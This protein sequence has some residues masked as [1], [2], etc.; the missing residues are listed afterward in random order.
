MLSQR[1]SLLADLRA[2]Q[3]DAVTQ[4]LLLPIDVL[5]GMT[6]CLPGRGIDNF[7]PDKLPSHQLNALK[8]ARAYTDAVPDNPLSEQSRRL[9]QQVD[10]APQKKSVVL[11][12]CGL[13]KLPLKAILGGI[14]LS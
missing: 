2:G 12:A 6:A 10:P 14:V 11:P 4:R 13:T 7:D 3:A 8:L 5:I 9:L 1:I